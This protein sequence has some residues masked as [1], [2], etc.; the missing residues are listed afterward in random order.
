MKSVTHFDC[1][2][3]VKGPANSSE[4]QVILKFD[5]AQD[6]KNMNKKTVG[7]DSDT[8]H[9]TTGERMCSSFEGSQAV[10]LLLQVKGE[11]RPEK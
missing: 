11:I 7:G 3:S 9:L 5:S 4:R 10:S 8:L 6:N 1:H 2:F